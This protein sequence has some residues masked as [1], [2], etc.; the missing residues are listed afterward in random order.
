MGLVFGNE[1]GFTRMWIA[2]IADGRFFG[3]DSAWGP[4]AKARLLSSDQ[5]AYFPTDGSSTD[6]LKVAGTDKEYRD[7]NSEYV[8]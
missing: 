5:S 8:V 3:Y 7:T 6:C 2:K 1:N 4:D